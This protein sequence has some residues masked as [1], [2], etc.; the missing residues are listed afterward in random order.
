MSAPVEPVD[1]PLLSLPVVPEPAAGL[2]LR[3]LGLVPRVPVWVTDPDLIA[4]ILDGFIDIPDDL[5]G[6]S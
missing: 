1:S 5:V 2:L 4:S 3:G 6:G